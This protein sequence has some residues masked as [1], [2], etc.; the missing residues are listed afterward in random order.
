MRVDW[1][2]KTSLTQRKGRAGRVNDGICYRL[3]D[4]KFYESLEEYP[5]AEMLR[6][7]LD[8]IILKIKKYDTY[9][10]GTPKEVLSMAL[11]PP[12]L[13]SIETTVIRL[14]TVNYLF[15]FY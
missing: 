14:K 2:S 3:I 15:I 10:K 4:R 7:S 13:N 9:F 1:A 6:L 12:K 11:Q 5:K 8:K